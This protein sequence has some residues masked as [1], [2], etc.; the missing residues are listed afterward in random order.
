M[1]GQSSDN[2]AP[3]RL[4][5]VANCPSRNTR[6]LAEAVVRGASDP[7]IQDIEVCF[8]EPLEAAAQD[9][10]D[11]KGIVIGTTENFAG[12][13]GLIK[14]FF[15]RIYYPC[16]EETQ[17]LPYA[18]YVRAGN[19]GSGTRAAVE[20]IVTGLR[21]SPIQ[22][23]LILQGDYRESFETECQELGMLMAA[24]LESGIF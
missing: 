13:S 2:P 1:T 8:R 21:W 6:S 3:R 10:L 9:V 22:P 5:I 11:C 4:L 17:G 12:M 24:G 15:E 7:A 20:R 18:L 14:D 23:C 16:L 19:D